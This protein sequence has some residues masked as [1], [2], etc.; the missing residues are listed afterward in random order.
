MSGEIIMLSEPQSINNIVSLYLELMKRCLTF[1]IWGDSLEPLYITGRRSHLQ[2][3]VIAFLGKWL[4]QRDIF[5]YRKK[6]FDPKV[7]AEGKDHPSL[8][9]TMIGLKR[10]NNIQYCVEDVLINNV[11]GDLMET[12]IWRGGAVIFMRAILKA[13]NVTDRKVWAADSFQGLPKPDANKY[14][15]DKGD[16]HY[17]MSNLMVSLEEV[18]ENFSK[19]NLLDEQV[20]FLEGWFKDTLPRAPI[21]KLAVLRLDGDMYESTMD[22]LSCLYPKLSQGGYLIID[23]YAYNPACKQAVQ[24]YRTA[25]QINDQILEIDW[26]GVYWKRS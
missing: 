22:A 2:Q 25:Y 1:Y 5:I 10:L 6:Q 15:A 23:D 21:E 3:L 19:Y 11:P 20:C 24:D 8:A 14:P 12:G 7:R 4:G 9:H 13:Y 17:L 18:Q 16:I 26:S